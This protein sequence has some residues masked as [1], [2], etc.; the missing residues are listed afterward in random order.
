MK[1][2]SITLLAL[3]VIGCSSEPTATNAADSGTTLKTKYSSEVSPTESNEPSTNAP[4]DANAPVTNAP[5]TNAPATN[6]PATNVP[7]EQQPLEEPKFEKPKAG[8]EVAVIETKYGKI[9][10]KFR[11]DKAPKHVKNFKDLANKKFYDGTIFHR[12]IPGFMIQGGDPNTK[13]KNKKETYGQGGPGYG[14]IAEFNNLDH[15]RGVISMA[16]SSDPNSAG[17]Q[18]FVMVN[19]YPSLNK[20]YSAF[21]EV[22]SGLEVADKIVAQPRDGGDMPDE[23]VEMKVSIQKWPVK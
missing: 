10:F 20:Q 23:R 8:E 7:L 5:A 3:L 13:D 1:L 17:S 18:F 14:V 9:V 11:P 2:M 6:A 21:G 15:K 22:V 16:R 4:A 19:D 12:V